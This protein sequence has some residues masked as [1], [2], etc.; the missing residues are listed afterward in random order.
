MNTHP[1]ARPVFEDHHQV[2]VAAEAF[3]AALRE[4]RVD[5]LTRRELTLLRNDLSWMSCL[6]ADLSRQ[7]DV[8][9]ES[10]ALA[11]E[12]ARR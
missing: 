3:T 9:R 12:V 4:L 1:P 11:S 8:E 7:I 6:M 2:A 10:L 5:V